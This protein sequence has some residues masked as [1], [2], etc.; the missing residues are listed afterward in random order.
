M[1]G[2]AEVRDEVVGAD[3]TQWVAAIRHRTAREEAAEEED[4]VVACAA[5]DA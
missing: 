1:P 3:A 2:R 4:L 5:L